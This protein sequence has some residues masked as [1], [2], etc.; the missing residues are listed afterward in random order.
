MR[1]TVAAGL[2][3]LVGIATTIA[4]ARRTRTRRV[5]AALIERGDP[6]LRN[7]IVTAEQLLGQPDLTRAHMR[8]RVLAEAARRA[9]SID[10]R[11][12]I[13]IQKE[14]AVAAIAVTLLIV[15]ATVK[16]PAGTAP[17]I[18]K[19]SNSEIPKSTVPSVTVRLAAPA[20]S[21]R[22]AITLKDP[23]AI[24]VLAGTQGALPSAPATASDCAST[25]RSYKEPR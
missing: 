2:A 18:S 20:Y 7:L 8:D 21:G 9:A 12:A 25:A 11:R 22:A 5:A 1:S 17:Q 14:S 24:E 19:V 6:T 10:M 23:A 13:P 4:W 15:S 16:L 3:A